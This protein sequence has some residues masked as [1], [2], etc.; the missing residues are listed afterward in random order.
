MEVFGLPLEDISYRNC[1]EQDNE[2][3]EADLFEVCDRVHVVERQENGEIE[4]PVDDEPDDS[5][6]NALAEIEVMR[7]VEVED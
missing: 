1:H 5:D 7:A 4:H 3:P 2:V 6:D